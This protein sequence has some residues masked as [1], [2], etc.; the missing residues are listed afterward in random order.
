MPSQLMLWWI[1]AISIPGPTLPKLL[2]GCPFHK[3]FQRVILLVVE[4]V[5]MVVVTAALRVVTVLGAVALDGRNDLEMLTS[6]IL[7]T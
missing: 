7:G 2:S 3:V 1:A 5:M 4:V 6:L